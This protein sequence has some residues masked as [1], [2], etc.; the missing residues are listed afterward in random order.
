[1][2]KAIVAVLMMLGVILLSGVGFAQE[3]KCPKS[4]VFNSA[5]GKCVTPPRPPRSPTPRGSW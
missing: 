4:K 2:P 3:K 1:M 5:N